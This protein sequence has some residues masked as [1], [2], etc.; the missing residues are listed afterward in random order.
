LI[1]THIAF[2]LLASI[3]QYFKI[4]PC[5]APTSA[6]KAVFFSSVLCLHARPGAV[7]PQTT[8]NLWDLCSIQKTSLYIYMYKTCRN[9]WICLKMVYGPQMKLLLGKMMV[10]LYIYNREREVPYFQTNPWY[11][12]ITM[13]LPRKNTSSSPCRRLWSAWSM[14][15]RPISDWCLFVCHEV[16]VQIVIDRDSCRFICIWMCIYIYIRSFVMI[17]DWFMNI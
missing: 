8:I 15:V 14:R 17:G 9:H 11:I 6:V 10:N 16:C 1:H 7:T 12:F 4:Q 3:G 13:P 2:L 5:S